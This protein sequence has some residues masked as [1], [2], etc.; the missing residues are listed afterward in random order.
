MA[1]LWLALGAAA[2]YLL[3]R[4]RPWD[5]LDTWAWRRLTFGG[6][7]TH[8]KLQVVLTFWV[9]ALVRPAATWHAWRHRNDPPPKSPP[10]TFQH[11]DQ[12]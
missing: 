4:I 5:R 9:H 12:P 8:S 6:P 10:V 2:G 7:W 11:P 1:L 3:G